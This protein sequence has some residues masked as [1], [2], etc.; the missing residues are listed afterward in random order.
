[1]FGLMGGGD[2][3][4]VLTP[5][6]TSRISRR[7]TRRSRVHTGANATP[8][9]RQ[10]LPADARG[11]PCPRRDITA[12]L[13]DRRK[14]RDAARVVLLHVHVPEMARHLPKNSVARELESSGQPIWIRRLEIERQA[15]IVSRP[16]AVDMVVCG[17]KPNLLAVPSRPDISQV[18]HPQR[19]A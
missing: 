19:F 17:H 13:P 4:G 1:M 14:W 7:S 16:S 6:E 3:E 11:V 10:P 5:Q 15:C 8:Q 2:A 18:E 12:R 9:R